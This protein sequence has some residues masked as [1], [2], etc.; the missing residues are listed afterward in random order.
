M[1]LRMLMLQVFS[2]DLDPFKVLY[3]IFVLVILCSLPRPSWD[4]LNCPNFRF[5]KTESTSGKY[6]VCIQGIIK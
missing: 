5:L 2:L 3:L 1:K 6:I 4:P